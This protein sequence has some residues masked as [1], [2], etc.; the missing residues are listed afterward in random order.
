MSD[1]I[2]PTDSQLYLARVAAQLGLPPGVEREIVEELA[3]HVAD[4]TEALASDGL[5]AG[6]AER[7]ALARLGNPEALADDIRRAQQTTRRLATAGVRATVS[8]ARAGFWWLL[9]SYLLLFVTA[10]A[11]WILMSAVHSMLPD[12]D[13]PLGT[14]TTFGAMAFVWV[15]GAFF[16]AREAVLVA[17]TVARRPVVQVGRWGAALGAPVVALWA[18]A[19]FEAEL[20]WL[21]VLGL[22]LVPVAFVAGCLAGPRVRRPDHPRRWAAAA[23]VTAMIL[24]AAVAVGAPSARVSGEPPIS[25]DMGFERVAPKLP[26]G[27]EPMYDS[28]GAGLPD[29]TIALFKWSPAAAFAGWHDLRLEAW[30]GEPTGAQ[31]IAPDAVAPFATAVPE[32]ADGTLTA[33]LRV[34]GRPGVSHYWVVLTGL[35]GSGRRFMLESPFSGWT[36]FHGSVADWVTGVVAPAP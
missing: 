29:G 3:S 36:T 2:R 35:D 30:R 5:T 12:A 8:F 11:V 26:K 25:G 32:V 27:S 22:L 1:P 17:A 33:S 19:I 14:V 4:A 24:A 18:L 28:A 13:P 34:Q 15:V 20:D 21:A 6:Q 31:G 9:V 7:E 16:G 23:A 10:I